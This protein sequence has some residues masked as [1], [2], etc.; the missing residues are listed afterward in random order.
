MILL[1]ASLILFSSLCHAEKDIFYRVIVKTADWDKSGTG[2]DVYINLH[3]ERG[4]IN[5]LRLK[6]SKNN[7]KP[8]QI[9][10][11]DIFDFSSGN[12]GEILSITVVLDFQ[13]IRRSWLLDEISI[14]ASN[15][16]LQYIFPCMCWFD[17][18]QKSR[19][20]KALHVEPI[21]NPGF[22]ARFTDPAIEYITSVALE[23][24]MTVYQ[25][26]AIP[27]RYYD[28]I[29][30]GVGLTNLKV[31]YMTLPEVSIEKEN[32][33]LSVAVKIEKLRIFSNYTASI[34][35]IKGG[36][37][38]YTNASNFNLN[39]QLSIVRSDK[40]KPFV[41]LLGCDGKA[42]FN[43][44]FNGKHDSTLN[45]FTKSM[46]D[47]VNEEAYNDI[48]TTLKEALTDDINPMIES[49]FPTTLD[50]LNSGLCFDLSLPY[51]PKV[52]TNSIETFHKGLF[53]WG[54]EKKPMWYYEGKI[55]VIPDRYEDN[56]KMAYVYITDYLINSAMESAYEGNLL[57]YNVT[58]D[59]VPEDYQNYFNY[60]NLLIPELKTDGDPVISIEA[61]T[62]P[63]I[64]FEKG[65]IHINSS[66]EVDLN[67][68]EKDRTIPVLTM[69][70]NISAS[71]KIAYLD[72]ILQCNIE[73]ITHESNVIYN[74]Y[75]AFGNF[76]KVSLGP[77]LLAA[78]TIVNGYC[79]DGINFEI[80]DFSDLVK[81]R[82]AE[83]HI[84][85]KFSGILHASTNLELSM[86]SLK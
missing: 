48:C 79:K 46:P 51:T 65:S 76:V 57:Q 52:M 37:Y 21:P 38:V 60:I 62:I 14:L 49:N 16:D 56:S 1:I 81:I 78:K 34:L 32:D 85:E 83:V 4:D 77:S 36:G 11:T 3:G 19:E 12:I 82:N 26:M 15:Y 64:N 73:E 24:G 70:L 45:F 44:K 72:S 13:I 40:N 67:M 80:P 29:V 58:K 86:D 22:K 66:L 33:I 61:L 53:T 10:Q 20:L 50:I 54:C 55:P 28:K 27:D 74:P 35:A 7:G 43:L 69:Q 42:D 63:Q 25:D 30:A 9:G 71:V 6:N 84:D 68:V 59:I 39:I 18:N 31:L 47:L 41:K 5:K 75:P 8:L 23:Y 2:G 17:K